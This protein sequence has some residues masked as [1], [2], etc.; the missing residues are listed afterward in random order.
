M[1]TA[2]MDRLLKSKDLTT[3]PTDSDASRAFKYWLATFQNFV[4]AV[5]AASENS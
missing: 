4:D 3:E 1:L 5:A 2:L